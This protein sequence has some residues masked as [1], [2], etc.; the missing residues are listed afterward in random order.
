MR[1]TGGR[2]DVWADGTWETTALGPY[3]KQN[4]DVTLPEGSELISHDCIGGKRCK[5]NNHFTD[6]K[7]T[8][9]HSSR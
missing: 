2:R 7:S 1:G 9:V 5:G 6:R 3:S 4:P 8:Y